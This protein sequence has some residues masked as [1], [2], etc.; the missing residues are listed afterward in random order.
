MIATLG[1]LVLGIFSMVRGGEFAKKYG[2]KLM[3]A[4]VYCQGAALGFFALALLSRAGG[5]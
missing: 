1:V 5:E 2:N 3:W 4:R